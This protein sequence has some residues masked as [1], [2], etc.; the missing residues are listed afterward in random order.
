VLCNDSST[1]ASLVTEVF[2]G[3][4]SETGA[5]VT[6]SS[7]LVRFRGKAVLRALYGSRHDIGFMWRGSYLAHRR[8]IQKGRHVDAGKRMGILIDSYSPF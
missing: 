1:T 8:A 6:D 5:L 4:V 2:P 7:I 3:A